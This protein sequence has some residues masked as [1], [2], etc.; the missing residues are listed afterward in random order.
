MKPDKKK[1]DYA[2]L[3]E[4][5][6]RALESEKLIVERMHI[7]RVLKSLCVIAMIKSPKDKARVLKILSALESPGKRIEEHVSALDVMIKS[8]KDRSEV[9]KT[10]RTLE[11]EKRIGA[12]MSA[13]E[14]RENSSRDLVGVLGESANIG[15]GAVSGTAVS[16]TVGS[17]M[18]V[19]TFLGSTILANVA[20]GFGLISIVS[21]PVGWIIGTAVAG[22]FIA[23]VIGKSIRSGGMNDLRKKR[24]IKDTEKRINDLHKEATMEDDK[25]NKYRQFIEVLI[26]HVY[27]KRLTPEKS[28]EFFHGVTNGSISI[29]F[30]LEIMKDLSNAK[31]T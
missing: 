30:A 25:E 22:G 14:K 8:P 7:L 15:L 21:T 18:G 27:N 28:S 19:N 1:P 31:T 26:I 9:S 16:A 12:H 10:L 24:V 4:G 6:L 11:I 17:F 23:G 20:T 13:N 3:I 2:K 29:E 5:L